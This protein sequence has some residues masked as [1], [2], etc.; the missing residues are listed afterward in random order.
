MTKDDIQLLFEYDRWANDRVF[1]AAAAL[2][3]EQFTRD[4]GGGFRSVR[5]TLVH[6]RLG[7]VGLDSVLEGGAPQRRLPDKFVDAAQYHVRSG[8]VSR[9]C[10]GAGKVGEV[11]RDQAEF[12]AG[13]TNE[14][15]QRMLP[16]R[17]KQMSLGHVMHHVANH[18]RPHRGQFRS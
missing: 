6:I 11:A 10:C 17:D 15:L 13:V 1:Q 14:S 16:V 8:Y 4:L 7:R 12:V 5:D 3:A 2:R 9:R 18:P